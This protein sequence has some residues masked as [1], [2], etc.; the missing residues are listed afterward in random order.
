[1]KSRWL[2]WIA[3][4]VEVAGFL[5][6]IF[7]YQQVL[8]YRR[9]MGCGEKCAWTAM[10][11]MLILSMGAYV[12]VPG[13]LAALY[14]SQQA[15]SR[16]RQDDGPM[17]AMIL[18]AVPIVMLAGLVWLVAVPPGARTVAP[19]TVAPLSNA[20]QELAGYVWA[21]DTAIVTEQDCIK[22]SAPFIEGCKR[23]A[24]QRSAAPR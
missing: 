14:F 23:Y 7:L 13:T 2:L 3:S 10:G 4:G 16:W 21:S 9:V 12:V 24:R 17:T 5:V 8:D 11:L 15:Y 6:L 18:H 20:D 1:M 22:G 19:K